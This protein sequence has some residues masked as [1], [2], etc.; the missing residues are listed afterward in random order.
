MLKMYV[1]LTVK[2]RNLC[3]EA[4]EIVHVSQGLLYLNFCLFIFIDNMSTSDE[5]NAKKQRTSSSNPLPTSIERSNVLSDSWQVCFHSSKKIY[6]IIHV[7]IT[8]T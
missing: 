2:L 5:P 4:F 3:E 1:N 7:I 8:I 6:I